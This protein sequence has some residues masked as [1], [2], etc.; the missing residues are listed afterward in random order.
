MNISVASTGVTH[1]AVDLGSAAGIVSPSSDTKVTEKDRFAKEIVEK[2]KKKKSPEEKIIELEKGL[3][4][5]LGKLGGLPRQE[6][7]R[8]ASPG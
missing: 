7:F 8:F 3:E 1:E 5:F 6:Q 2:M 4:A